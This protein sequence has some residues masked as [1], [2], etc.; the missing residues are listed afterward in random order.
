EGQV[1]SAPAPLDDALGLAAL[2]HRLELPEDQQLL[3]A[4][5]ERAHPV[6]DAGGR[7]VADRGQRRAIGAGGSRLTQASPFHK[8]MGADGEAVVGCDAARDA[9]MRRWSWD[10]GTDGRSHSDAWVGCMVCSTTASSS[11]VRVSRST[12]WRSRAL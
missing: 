8:A 5:A 11:L 10:A 4:E 12:C 6:A 3:G 1:V 2:A 7:L 9:S